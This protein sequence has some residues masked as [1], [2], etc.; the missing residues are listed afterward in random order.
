MCLLCICLLAMCTLICVT[1]F[2]PPSVRGWLRPLLVAL[3]GL[4]C[5]PFCLPVW[6]PMGNICFYGN[7]V[8]QE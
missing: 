8:A 4:F 1:F 2:L 3:S 7:Q 6:L 5:L